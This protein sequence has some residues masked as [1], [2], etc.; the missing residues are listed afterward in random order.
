[1]ICDCC[2]SERSE[3]LFYDNEFALHRCSACGL[4]YIWPMPTASTRMTE[5]E[6]GH[7]AST[8]SVL[9]ARKQLASERVQRDQ[10]QRY[11]E[12][13]KRHV[14]AGRWLDIGCGAGL[15]MTLVAAAGFDAEGIELTADRRVIA[16]QTTGLPVF[17]RPVE[18]ASFPDEAFAVISLINV[19]SHLVSPRGTLAELRR[20]LRPGGL[21]LLVTG[22][23][24]PGI[25]KSHV[26]GW[27][28][29]DHLFFLSRGT[30][31]H[32]AAE[33]SLDIVEC[34]RTW[35][36]D[37]VY[38]REYLS[39]RGRSAVRNFAKQALLATPIALPLLRAAVR[40][41]Q[42]GNEAYAATYV[43]RRPMS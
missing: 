27:N 36:P 20:I 35:L 18:E 25:Q 8:K 42:A 17:D 9:S 31:N 34:N 10:F 1:M 40:R 30:L 14:Q 5:M 39:I 38:S 32:Y 3:R 23:L 33:G 11:V 28:L 37:V 19:F 41:Y 26:Q 12:L 15:L 29:G 43:L 24:G 2:A 6:Q 13:A 7:F 4:L 16:Q 21:L 22:E